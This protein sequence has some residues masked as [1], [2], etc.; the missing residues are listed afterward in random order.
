LNSPA[1]E[2]SPGPVKTEL[3]VGYE[4]VD[5]LIH[6]PFMQYV[7]T[8]FTLPG[9]SDFNAIPSSIASRAQKSLEIAIKHVSTVRKLQTVDWF[10]IKQ[11]LLAT[12]LVIAASK[13]MDEDVVLE[14]EAMDTL[15][16][17]TEIFARATKSSESAK[18]ALQL[19]SEIRVSL[20][21]IGA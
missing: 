15:N 9:F 6:R 16:G 8:Q 2:L 13:V 18:R 14:K 17:A 11:V 10:T 4:A 7:L 5:F 20:K 12:L 3:Q 19:V 1:N 21:G